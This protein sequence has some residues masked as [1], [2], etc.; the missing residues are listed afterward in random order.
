MRIGKHTIVLVG[1]VLASLVVF[2]S[3]GAGQSSE[4]R[5]REVINKYGKIRDSLY[6]CH[7]SRLQHSLSSGDRR[8]C[9]RRN[10]R[11]TLFSFPGE[12]YS[13]HVHCRTSRCIETPSGSPPADGPIPEGS[14]VYCWPRVSCARPS[15]RSR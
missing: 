3:S 5:Q 1:A 13:F 10:R 6:V 2:P 8:S 15:R 7:V 14:E 11:Y 4:E 9:R 12:G